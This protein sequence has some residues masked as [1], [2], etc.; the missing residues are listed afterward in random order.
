MARRVKV[1][2]LSPNGG[3]FSDVIEVRDDY[4]LPLISDRDDWVEIEGA[5][6]SVWAM[7]P[8][9]IVGIV[10]EK[11]KPQKKARGGQIN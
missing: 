9:L 2:I 8:R 3:E 6:G 7:P 1:T 10:L 5:D 4:D 11:K